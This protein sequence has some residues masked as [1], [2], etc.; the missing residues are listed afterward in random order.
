M[1]KINL[2]EF[3]FTKDMWDELKE[4]TRPIVI[5]GM[6]N[7]ADKLIARFQ[8]LGI[9]YADIFASDGFVRGHSFHGTRVKSFSEIRETYEDFVIVLSFASNRSEVLEMLKDINESYTMVAPDMPV[10]GDEYFDKSFYNLNY[11][12][13]VKAYN[14]LAD[15][16]SKNIFASCLR[17]KLTG[18]IS[19]LYD[20]YCSTD[21]IYELLGNKHKVIVDAGAYNGDTVRESL[22][23]FPELE[24]VYAIEPDKRNY[25]KLLK[26]SEEKACNA[27]IVPL[28][29]AAWSDNGQA[30]FSGSGNRNSSISAT[31][32]YQ[33]REELTELCRIDGIT[34]DAVDYIKYDVEGAEMEALIGSKKTIEAFYPDLLISLYHRSADLFELVN[35][36]NEQYPVYKLFIRRTLCLPAWEI[37]LI[38]KK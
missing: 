14:S 1:K 35:Y 15:E 30:C 27:E 20:A 31:A 6:G 11:E 21:E 28:N 8:L 34:A 4:E 32:S 22:K 17:Y 10:A 25:K 13:I 12:K 24:K 9:E 23:Y 29:C 2:P 16:T 36:I 33:K 18:R 38:A 37:A 26:F 5:Y 3:P 7:G 19:Y